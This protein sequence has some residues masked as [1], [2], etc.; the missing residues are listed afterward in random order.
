MKILIPTY[1]RSSKLQ[2]T[3]EYYSLAMSSLD[4]FVV[5]DGSSDVYAEENEKICNIF[6][7][8]WL[9]YDQSLGLYERLL[10][11]LENTCPSDLVV[12][13]NDEDVFLPSYLERAES[14]M[15]K[16]SEYSG[17]IGRYITFA[18]PLLWFKRISHAR[19]F[20]T[21]IDIGFNDPIRRLSLCSSTLLAGCS[22]VY[23]SIRRRLQL[24]ESLHAQ[25]SMRYE[26]TKELTDQAHLALSGKLYFSKELM[27]IRDESKID[28]VSPDGHCS[29]DDYIDHA[30]L[31]NFKRQLKQL[32]SIENLDL[33]LQE[34]MDM[35]TKV[36]PLEGYKDSIDELPSLCISRHSAYFS[37]FRTFSDPWWFPEEK[38]V[39]TTAKIGIVLSEIISWFFVKRFLCSVLPKRAVSVVS[40]RRSTTALKN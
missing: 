3:L 27:L 29:G 33:G 25:M 37:S 38:F 6:G 26:S 12:V 39:R 8:E 24:V 30:D 28:Y 22:P 17:Y 36:K 31:E 19:D 15:L 11:Y 32:F 10:T 7:V 34:V 35:W 18:R 2:R 1:N 4:S 21:C 5:L 40:Q 23:F 14:F 13:A 20:V 9:G 16:N